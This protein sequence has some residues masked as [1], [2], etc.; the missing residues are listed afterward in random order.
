MGRVIVWAAESLGMAFL[1]IGGFV[2]IVALGREP[3]IFAGGASAMLGGLSLLVAG[4][5]LYV[6]RQILARLPPTA[7]AGTPTRGREP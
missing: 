6:L 3:V 5:I 1:L 7:P 4:E 2:A